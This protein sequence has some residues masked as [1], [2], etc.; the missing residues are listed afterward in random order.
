MSSTNFCSLKVLS[1][2]GGATR[3]TKC[4]RIS[5]F[6]RIDLCSRRNQY[7]WRCR[8]G[9]FSRRD[10]SID[11]KPNFLFLLFCLFKCYFRVLG[12]IL[13]WKAD[14]HLVNTFG[15][16]IL[17]WGLHRKKGWERVSAVWSVSTVE[18]FVET[19][20]F[21]AFTYIQVTC[22]DDKNVVSENFQLFNWRTALGI[23]KDTNKQ[24]NILFSRIPMWKSCIFSSPNS[25]LC[26]SPNKCLNF[27]TLI[28]KATWHFCKCRWID[29]F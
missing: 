27:G 4:R 28:F 17:R 19:S 21:N 22:Y 16:C 18:E 13:K 3:N 26:S 7:Q 11:R 23:K 1:N 6:C 25:S 2:F 14:T 29:W 15:N 20:Y 12:S 8:K 5:A 9:L 24:I 10:L